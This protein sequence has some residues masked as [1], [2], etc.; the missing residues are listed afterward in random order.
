MKPL[1]TQPDHARVAA[2]V[3]AAETRTS[4]ELRVVLAHWSSLYGA[5]ALIYPAVAALIGGGIIAALQPALGAAWL[6]LREA[7]IFLVLLALL[8]WHALRRWLT[9]PPIKRKAAWRHARLHYAAIGLKQPHTRNALLLFCSA[10]ERTVEIL[11][12]DAIAEKLP[13][14]VWEP[15]IARFKVHFTQGRIADAYVDAVAACAGILAP[16][17]PASPGQSN[18][19]PDDLVEI[20]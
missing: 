9:P 10:A 14:S 13:A 8:Q 16:V 18:E 2:A 4:V 3:A 15:V 11:V 6:F 17:F 1:H 7:A 5:F 19:L 12:D 20:T